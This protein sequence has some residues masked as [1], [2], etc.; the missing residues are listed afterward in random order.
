MATELLG[1]YAEARGWLLRYMATA[2]FTNTQLTLA[3][4]GDWTVYPIEK[5]SYIL[6]AIWGRLRQADNSL[7]NGS[8]YAQLVQAEFDNFGSDESDIKE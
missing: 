2:R 3:L 8:E 6:G 1:P 5:A 7:E 4:Q